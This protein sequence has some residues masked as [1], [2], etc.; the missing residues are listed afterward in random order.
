MK[1]DEV[2]YVEIINVKD[3]LIYIFRGISQLWYTFFGGIFVIFLAYLEYDIF[4]GILGGLLLGIYISGQI[5]IWCDVLEDY[6]K[7]KKNEK[8]TTTKTSN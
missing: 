2:E 4:L 8:T 5:F 6:Q 7:R 3:M 1:K